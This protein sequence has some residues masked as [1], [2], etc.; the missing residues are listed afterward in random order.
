MHSYRCECWA[1][2][3]HNIATSNNVEA[4][5]L[6]CAISWPAAPASP[7][8][9]STFISS[10]A[11]L[12]SRGHAHTVL[13]DFAYKL[14]ARK[15]MLSPSIPGFSW[16]NLGVCA[17]LTL[18]EHESSCHASS[19]S[20]VAG[21]GDGGCVKMW[22][23]AQVGGVVDEVSAWV[24]G[25]GGCVVTSLPWIQGEAVTE[26]FGRWQRI[27]LAVTSRSLLFLQRVSFLV[28]TCSMSDG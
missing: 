13:L 8:S 14:R 6:S 2:G 18:C 9:M 24:G 28:S 25:K 23:G 7:R 22:L 27:S 26:L 12:E 19:P 21:L 1:T 4:W 5:A 10:W 15:V 16:S 17:P 3:Q 11:K 20:S